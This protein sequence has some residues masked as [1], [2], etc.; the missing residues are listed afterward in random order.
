MF[1]KNVLKLLWH[2]FIL[3]PMFSLSRIEDNCYIFTN[4]G[5]C[6]ICH[7]VWLFFFIMDHTFLLRDSSGLIKS[8]STCWITLDIIHRPLMKD[9]ILMACLSI[10]VSM[11]IVLCKY[12]KLVIHAIC[13]A[14]L[15]TIQ[16]LAFASVTHES[17]DDP[18]GL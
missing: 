10:Y 4:K 5:F 2:E 6:P 18:I 15:N 17:L 13:F 14:A 16:A 3:I 12:Y 9:L 7:V 11:S 8:H 1:K